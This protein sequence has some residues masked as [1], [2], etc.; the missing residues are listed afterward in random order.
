MSATAATIAR[1]PV[2]KKAGVKET[3]VLLALAWFIPFAVHLAPWSGPRPLGAYLLPMFWAAFIAVYFYGSV[4]GLIIGL[5]SPI[6]N[7]LV[8][9]LPAWKFLSVLSFEL[10]LSVLVATWAIRQWPR[11]FL[12]APLSYL[13]AKIGSTGL[14]AA[15]SVF[16]DIGAPGEFFVHSVVGSLPGLVVLAAINVALVWFY[17]KAV[18]EE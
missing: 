9:G 12:I 14:Q 16:G 10:A 13:V 6:L 7:L 4:M 2:F 8:T 1:A 17:P 18:R 3:A 11:F 5:F 15:T